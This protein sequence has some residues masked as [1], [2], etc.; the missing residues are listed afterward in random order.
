M[1]ASTAL[2]SY[3]LRA[4]AAVGKRI[5]RLDKNRIANFYTPGQWEKVNLLR[6]VLFLTT[7]HMTRSIS[8]HRFSGI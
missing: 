6:Y 8:D 1:P 5:P 3:P 7:A 2:G 4:Q